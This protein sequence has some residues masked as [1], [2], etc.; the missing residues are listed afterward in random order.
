MRHS[1]ERFRPLVVLLALAITTCAV[2]EPPTGGPEDTEPPIIVEYSPR[3]DSTGVSRET[4]VRIAFSEDL[5]S[6]SF[7]NRVRFYPPVEFDRVTVKGNR[8]EIRFREL[9]P[10]TTFCVLLA[11]GFK[12]HHGVRSSRNEQ[13]YFATSDSIERGQLSGHILFKSK[14]DSISVVKAFEIRADTAINVFK[15]EESRIAFTERDG[16]FRLRALPADSSRY[17]LWAFRDET[18]DGKYTSGKDFSLL[19]GDTLLLTTDKTTID[20]LVINVIDPNEPGSVQ[21]RVINESGIDE[22]AMIRF[23]P[24]LP[25][26]PPLLA[27]ADTTGHFKLIKVRPGGYLFS[28]FLD[29]APDSVCGSYPDPLDSTATLQEPCF[30]MPDTLVIGP[31]ESKTLEPVLLQ[32]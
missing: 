8:L 1:A 26:E 17:L 28:A 12:D 21:G 27:V 9:L 6:E 3:P 13:F 23:D 32:R 16:S 22:L 30:E 4:S 18:G 10:E 15:Q 25:G 7:K 14:L 2:I 29:I 11:A 31:G 19:F 5:D 20:G 24:L